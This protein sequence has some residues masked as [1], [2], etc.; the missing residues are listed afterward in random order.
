MNLGKKENP[1]GRSKKDVIN[2]SFSD[3]KEVKFKVEI[4]GDVAAVLQN[5]L[6]AAVETKGM[7]PNIV[8]HTS[9]E[10]LQETIFFIGRNAERAMQEAG[11]NPVKEVVR[12]VNAKDL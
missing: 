6:M 1:L 12:K 5:L 11:L 9:P 8:D 7:I 3:M 2:V 4:R 10:S